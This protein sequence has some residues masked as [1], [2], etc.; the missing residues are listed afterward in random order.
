[1]NT[2]S[3]RDARRHRLAFIIDTLSG[4]LLLLLSVASYIFEMYF[5]AIRGTLV[6]GFMLPAIISLFIASLHYSKFLSLSK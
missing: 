6:F 3:T 2:P 4:G 5:P 1:M